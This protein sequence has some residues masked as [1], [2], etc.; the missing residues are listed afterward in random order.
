MKYTTC[1]NKKGKHYKKL[2]Y[3]SYKQLLSKAF[4]ITARLQ[5]CLTSN[6]YNQIPLAKEMEYIFLIASNTVVCFY[7]YEKEITQDPSEVKETM[8]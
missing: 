8:L 1:Q 7:F 2:K 4:H 3:V 5:C 6:T